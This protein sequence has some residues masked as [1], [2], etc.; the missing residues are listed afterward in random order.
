MPLF[1]PDHRPAPTQNLL[2]VQGP[3]K[4]AEAGGC[5]ASCWTQHCRFQASGQQSLT[6][7]LESSGQAAL[8]A[9]ASSPSRVNQTMPCLSAGTNPRSYFKVLLFSSLGLSL[10]GAS[11]F[12]WNVTSVSL[13]EDAMLRPGKK[14]QC[15]RELAALLKDPVELPAPF[16]QLIHSY[17]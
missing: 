15:F 6:A 13:S 10:L 9:S 3:T 17:L 11:T 14:D 7:G 4:P 16:K 8:W 1:P 5:L 12:P 2:V